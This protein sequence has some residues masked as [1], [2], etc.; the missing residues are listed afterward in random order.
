MFM[1]GIMELI[2][3]VIVGSIGLLVP[4]ILVI[5]FAIK[6]KWKLLIATIVISFLAGIGAIILIPLGLYWASSPQINPYDIYNQDECYSYGYEWY[7]E[8]YDG[9]ECCYYPEVE[10]ARDYWYDGDQLEE[11][12]AVAPADEDWGDDW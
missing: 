9:W 8:D 4:L 6:K 10:A 7:C 5:V 12:D 3:V 11:T 1:M 2:I